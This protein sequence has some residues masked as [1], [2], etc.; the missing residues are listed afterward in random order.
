MNFWEN[1]PF[2][3][4]R[5]MTEKNENLFKKRTENNVFVQN[6]SINV[7]NMEPGKKIAHFFT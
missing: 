1:K 3:I 5:K 6:R 4:S 7:E 2:I